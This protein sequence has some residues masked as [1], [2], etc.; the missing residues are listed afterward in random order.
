MPNK[1]LGKIYLVLVIKERTY[2]LE[3]IETMLQNEQLS[4]NSEGYIVNCK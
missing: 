3:Q 2:I 1:S 4:R